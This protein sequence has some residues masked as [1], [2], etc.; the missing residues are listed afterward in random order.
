MAKILDRRFEDDVC[1]A[2]TE[3]L[4]SGGYTPEEIIPGL[5]KAITEQ[6]LLTDDAEQSIDEAVELME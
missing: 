1:F 4:E 5:A 2:V 3:A 6:A